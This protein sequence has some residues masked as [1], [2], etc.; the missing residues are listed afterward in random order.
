VRKGIRK[1]RIKFRRFVISV[2]ILLLCL[3]LI[4]CSEKIPVPNKQPINSHTEKAVVALTE[5]EIEE[6]AIVLKTAGPARFQVYISVPGE[7]EIPPDNL[8]HIHP[9]F[10]GMVKMVLKHIGDKVSEGE[11]L[12]SIESNESL[13]EYQIRSLINGTII[14]KH[15]TR[16]EIVEGDNNRHGA[17][18]F[19]LS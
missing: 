17:D 8:A 7:I 15:I 1:M 3:L 12:A 5:S 16:G 19:L 4:R 2:P 13:T 6:L 18:S 9:R 11:V 10:P 14:E